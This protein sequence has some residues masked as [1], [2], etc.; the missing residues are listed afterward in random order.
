[1][2]GR[3]GRILIAAALALA[4][5]GSAL[6]LSATHPLPGPERRTREDHPPGAGLRPRGGAVFPAPDARPAGGQEGDPGRH[7]RAGRRHADLP[8]QGPLRRRRFPRRAGLPPD[9]RPGPR[10]ARGLPLVDAQRTRACRQGGRAKWSTA[11]GAIRPRPDASGLQLRSRLPRRRQVQG[12]GRFRRVAARGAGLLRPFELGRPAGD[13]SGV[14]AKSAGTRPRRTGAL[15]RLAHHHAVSEGPDLGLLHRRAQDSCSATMAARRKREARL[16]STRMTGAIDVDHR[17]GRSASTTPAWRHQRQLRPRRPRRRSRDPGEMGDAG[18]ISAPTL[19]PRKRRPHRL[20]PGQ[21]RTGEDL[22]P[23]T[24]DQMGAPKRVCP[25][26]A[27][28]EA[29]LEPSP[30]PEEDPTRISPIATMS[31]TPRA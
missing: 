12:A 6:A 31:T 1:M 9:R 2:P 28:Q 22:P 21:R 8:A 20:R 15:A 18:G 27:A 26:L 30:G 16:R 5:A 11:T 4:G 13:R 24:G 19:R 23:L 3:P 29:E 10:G 17:Q 25:G 7:R 14:A